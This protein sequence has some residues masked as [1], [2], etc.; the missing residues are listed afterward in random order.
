[1]TTKLSEATGSRRNRVLVGLVLVFVSLGTLF[2][3][4]NQGDAQVAPLEP[5]WNLVAGPG[6]SPDAYAAAH[7]EC[8]DMMVWG[9]NQ[10]YR[11]PDASFA[12]GWRWWSNEV[13]QVLQQLPHLHAHKGY[14]VHCVYAED[15]E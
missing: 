13:P 7:H 4:L 12:S 11:D 10:E 5:G 14:W 1:M 15:S 8:V 9:W 6:E 2:A 3:L